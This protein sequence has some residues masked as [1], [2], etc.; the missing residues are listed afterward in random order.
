MAVIQRFTALI[1]GTAVDTIVQ[2]EN[3]QLQ[4]D[5]SAA[6]SFE[7]RIHFNFYNQIRL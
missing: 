3:A 7:N 1:V 5:P 4:G 2:T 6:V